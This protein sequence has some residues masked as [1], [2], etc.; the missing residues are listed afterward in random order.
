MIPYSNNEIKVGTWIN[1]KPMYRKVVELGLLP[2]NTTKTVSLRIADLKN[3]VKG[4]GYFFSGTIFSAMP[5][6]SSSQPSYSID[7]YFENGNAVITTYRDR[8]SWYGRA[9]VYYTKTTD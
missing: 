6:S 7:F 4:E 9:I 2:N 1:G 8:S 3:I 5:F